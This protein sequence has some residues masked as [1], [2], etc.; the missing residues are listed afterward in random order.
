MAGYISRIV[1]QYNLENLN[2][3]IAM[4]LFLLL[5]PIFY[6]ISM[7]SLLGKIIQYIEANQLIP[8]RPTRITC[9]FVIGDI[10]SLIMQSTGGA[11]LASGNDGDSN[12]GTAIVLIGLVIQLIFFVF[13][14]IL[15]GVFHYKTRDWEVKLT[16]N[17]WKRL[18]KTLEAASVLILVRSIYRIVEYAQGYD[19]YLISHEVYLYTLDALLMLLVQFLFN[20]VHPGSVLSEKKKRKTDIEMGRN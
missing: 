15:M 10:I 7:Y 3:Y 6:A 18:L 5:A 1:C 11:I 9:I 16:Q 17:N 13:F 12:K 2:A 20:F 8:I 4:T 14:I 19:G